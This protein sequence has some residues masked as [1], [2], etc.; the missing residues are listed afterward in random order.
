MI[1]YERNYNVAPV[2]VSS[3]SMMHPSLYTGDFS[4]LNDSAKPVVPSGVTLTPEEIVHNTIQFTDDDGNTTTR[5]VTIPSRLLNPTVQAMINTYFPK[6]GLSA[7]IDAATGIIAGGYQTIVPGRSVQDLGTFRL[8][9]DFSERDHLYGVYNVSAQ[10]SATTNVVNPYTGLG[11][12]QND[13]K[14]HTVA[15]SYTHAVAQQAE[16]SLM[17]FSIAPRAQ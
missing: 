6:I 1:A 11:L 16:L 12:T 8:D 7:P 17:R 5:F 10:V 14:N 3:D 15:L 4:G 13:R 9:H 2:K